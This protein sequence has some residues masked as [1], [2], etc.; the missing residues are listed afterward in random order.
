M[1]SLDYETGSTINR[2]HPWRWALVAGVGLGVGLATGWVGYEP[3]LRFILGKAQVTI[4]SIDA[5]ISSEMW[6]RAMAAIS[7]VLV[8]C[9]GVVAGGRR[10]MWLGWV[11]FAIVF[12][13][14]TFLGLLASRS[15]WDREVSRVN[16]LLQLP[17]LALPGPH[18]TPGAHA[19]TTLFVSYQAPVWLLLAPQICGCVAVLFALFVVKIFQ[20]SAAAAL[21]EKFV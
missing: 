17:R 21:K 16:R 4:T 6:F 9:C 11:G 14:G 5:L 12:A 7:G 3:T 15:V 2:P 1:A 20:A 13:I 18:S 19:I 10:K 8:G